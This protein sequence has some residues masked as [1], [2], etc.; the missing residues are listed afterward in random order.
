MGF[1]GGWNRR[2]ECS[3]QISSESTPA[4]VPRTRA[5][6]PTAA[7]GVRVGSAGLPGARNVRS[8]YDQHTVFRT[9]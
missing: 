6:C 5:V 7:T 9:A 3:E 2:G 4:M 1:L 8:R